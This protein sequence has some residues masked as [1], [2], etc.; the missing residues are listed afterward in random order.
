VQLGKPEFFKD[1]LFQDHIAYSGR[2][3]FWFNFDS[4]YQAE[5]IF[6]AV[7]YG[8]ACQDVPSKPV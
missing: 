3:C 8:P 4:G 2:D 1:A 5:L 7:T 6:T